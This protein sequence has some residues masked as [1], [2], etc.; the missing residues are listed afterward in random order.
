VGAVNPSTTPVLEPAGPPV[1]EAAPPISHSYRPDLDG[2]RSIAVYLVLLFHTGLGWAK[3]GFIGV[4]LF[5]VLSG[6]LVSSVLLSEIEKSGDLRLGRFYAR[7]VRRLLPAAVMT[8]AA[9]CLTFT[10]LWS[11]VRRLGIIGDAQSALLYYANWHFISQSGDYFAT[12]VETS[13]FLHFWSLAIEE[14]FYVFFPI[15]LLLLSKVGRRAM[16]TVLAAIF[17]VSLVAQV[18]WAQ[19]DTTRAYY[20]T[21]ARV[22]QL[23][24]GALLTV[25][26]H[27]WSPRLLRGARAHVVALAGLV[28]VLLLGSGLVDVNPSL[29]GI[30]A[31]VVSVMLIGGLML[32]DQQ[33]L[34]RLLGRPVPVF[35]GRISYGTY[36]WHWPVIAALTTLFDTSPAIIAIF[37]L[38]LGTGLAALSYEV[39]EMPIRKSKLLNRF[40]WTVALVG[41]G[42]SALVAVTLVPN[43]LE[44]DRKPALSSELTGPSTAGLGGGAASKPIPQDIDWHKVR[45]SYGASHWCKADDGPACTVRTGDGPHVLFIGDSQAVTLVP[46][47]KKLANEHDLTLS[48]DVLSGCPWQEGLQNAKQEGGSAENCTKARVDWYDDALAE[49]DPDVVIL[50]D[51]P[52]DDPE[53]WSDLVSRRDGKD[54][55]LAQAVFETT[56]D[57]L[58]KISAVA[59]KTVVIQRLVM[60][61]TFNPT[62]CLATQTRIGDCAVPV[63]SDPSPSDGYFAAAAAQSPSILAV[64]LTP[65]FCPTAPVCLPIMRNKVVWRDDHHYTSD[66]AMARR[67]AVW[68]VLTDSGAFDESTD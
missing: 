29:R 31:M 49:I 43:L 2:L 36:L 63:P 42:V 5:F 38:A 23:F 13:P 4:D 68:K 48:L 67:A 50:L 7:R 57:T 11:V 15:L 56:R 26:L 52:R 10:V 22:Y 60:P 47:F 9:T 51:R 18:Y 61:E 3:G 12:D 27:T 30:G 62:D 24:A 14:Q 59:D 6:F 39:L 25:V 17:A 55:P 54:Q 20:G 40:S 66:Y 34:S 44:Q 37:A 32:G 28:G 1:T 8:I 65:A 21:D 58:D 35:L 46:M 53:L 33:P 19:V 45:T 41:V 64:N 16:L